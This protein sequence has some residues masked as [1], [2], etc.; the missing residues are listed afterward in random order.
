MEVAPEEVKASPTFPEVDHSGL[1]RV[2]A[3]TKLAHQLRCEPVGL[4]SFLPGPT[5]DNEV[6]P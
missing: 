4:L 2:Q 1:A 5:G 3:E 6:V